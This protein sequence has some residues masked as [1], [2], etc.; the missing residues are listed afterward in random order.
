MIKIKKQPLK[1]VEEDFFFFFL[2]FWQEE[3]EANIIE[4][5]EPPLREGEE[6][7]YFNCIFLTEKKIITENKGREVEVEEEHCFLLFFL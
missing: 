2:L 5:K 1:E 3:E 6:E 7:Y 4:N